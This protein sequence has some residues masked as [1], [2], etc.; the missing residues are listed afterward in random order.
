[1][2]D[3]LLLQSSLDLLKNQARCVFWD[4]ISGARNMALEFDNPADFIREYSWNFSPIDIGLEEL[5][6]FNIMFDLRGSFA[7]AVLAVLLVETY[8][9]GNEV[10]IIE[11]LK[12]KEIV[13]VLEKLND[14]DITDLETRMNLANRLI[15]LEDYR[16]VVV[17]NDQQF[18]PLSCCVSDIKYSDN[19]SYD[20]WAVLKVCQIVDMALRTEDLEERLDCLNSAGLYCPDLMMVKENSLITSA[21]LEDDVHDI[22]RS[23]KNVRPTAKLFYKMWIEFGATDIL[24]K[25]PREVF[26]LLDKKYSKSFKREI[27]SIGIIGDGLPRIH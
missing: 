20:P 18:D 26:I 27:N 17:I 4:Q 2:D 8:F 12:K 24:A 11:V 22:V 16:I 15:E 21:F 25:Y 6:R 5:R 9:F 3:V 7:R 1:M 10:K 23:L 19:K 13:D 14:K